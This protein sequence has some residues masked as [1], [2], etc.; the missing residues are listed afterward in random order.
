MGEGTVYCTLE[1]VRYRE[2][3]TLP[4]DGK[5]YTFYLTYSTRYLR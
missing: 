2:I 4:A 3:G 1:Y 5:L